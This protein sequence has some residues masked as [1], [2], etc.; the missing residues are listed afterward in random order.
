MTLSS[1]AFSISS[2]TAA[3]FNGSVACK[4]TL[5]VDGNTTLG[6]AA[7]DTL[8]INGTA[9]TI[10]NSLN[11]DGNTLYINSTTDRVGIGAAPVYKLDVVSP[12]GGA[13]MFRAGISG[14]TNGFT[15]ISD[16]SDVI[17]YSFLTSASVQAFKI[18]A[19]S[20]TLNQGPG[21]L[22]YG[23]GS[24]GS[25]TQG[26]NRTTGVTLNKTNGAITLVSAA[27][28]T[29]WQSFTVSNST[30]ATTDTVIVNQKSGTDLYEIHVTA[31]GAGSFRLTYRTTAGTTIE[32]PVF[33]FAVIKAVTA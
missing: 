24:G 12:T 2:A 26:T 7:A 21:G 3:T 17:T 25:V 5:S 19:S 30:V 29:A 31:V 8:T 10:P 13:N 9:V 27:G 33:N 22:G 6:D 18:D 20:N 14:K 11:F 28:T 32:Q 4:T 1:T 23:T 16:A 15:M